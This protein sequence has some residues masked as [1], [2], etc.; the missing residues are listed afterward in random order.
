M[1]RGRPAFGLSLLLACGFAVA[2]EPS[3]A[4]RHELEGELARLVSLLSDGYAKAYPEYRA[5]SV[6]H[7]FPHEGNGA[8]VLFSIEGYA[9]TNDH[10][11]YLAY[12]SGVAPVHAGKPPPKRFQLLAFSQIGGRSWRSYDYETLALGASAVTIRGNAYGE[13]DPACCPSV[14]IRTTFRYDPERGIVEEPQLP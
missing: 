7:L 14:P 3:P 4:E 13:A 12:F 9:G 6:G 8:A 2:A 1:S 10:N 5:I 11:E